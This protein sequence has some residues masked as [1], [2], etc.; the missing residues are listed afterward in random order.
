M[1]PLQ[2][3]NIHH[4]SRQGRMSAFLGLLE[5]CSPKSAQLEGTPRIR[6]TNRAGPG[7]VEGAG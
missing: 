2:L 6:R 1:L 3:G 7:G 4:K 5:G